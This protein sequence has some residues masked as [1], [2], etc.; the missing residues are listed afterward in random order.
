MQRAAMASSLQRLLGTIKKHGSDVKLHPM[1]AESWRML[2]QA[3]DD[4][5]RYNIN[6]VKASTML[7]DV[8]ERA[9]AQYWKFIT[10][11]MDIKRMLMNKE[12]TTCDVDAWFRKSITEFNAATDMFTTSDW[13]QIVSKLMVDLDSFFNCEDM[14]PSMPL[15]P[16]AKQI[17]EAAMKQAEATV[18]AAR[19]R[20]I[21]EVSGTSSHSTKSTK[22]RFDH[23]NPTADQDLWRMGEYSKH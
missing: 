1:S 17:K 8:E 16:S 13:I 4:T 15:T 2:M 11:Q 7:R 3:M 12:T 23:P 21:D 22:P 20:S 10:I 6:D 5:V 9:D 19:K 14:R 18:Q